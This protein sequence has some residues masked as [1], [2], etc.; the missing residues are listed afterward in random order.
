MS[1]RGRGGKFNKVKRGG[2]KKFSRDLQPL[3]ADGEVVGMWGE[4]PDKV[5]EESSE[6]EA[7][8]E[9]ES[10][11]GEGKPADEELTREQRRE[12]AKK[13][14]AAAIAKK[15]QKAPEAGDMPTDSEEDEDDDMPANPNHT[16][17]ARTQA[18]KAPVDPDAEPAAT[19]A[20]KGKGKQPDLSQL[21]RREREALQA[22]A[23]KDR[24]E[25]LHAEGKTEQARADLERLRLVRER[26]DAEAARKKAEAEER[27]ELE[28]EKKELM[29][30]ENR[31]R[32]QAQGKANRLAKGGKKNS[33]S[34][35]EREKLTT[36]SSLAPLDKHRHGTFGHYLLRRLNMAEAVSAQ[37]QANYETFRDCLSEPILKALAVPIEQA[38]PKKN[39]KRYAKKGL[40]SSKKR[41]VQQET[42]LA[43]FQPSSEA[44]QADAE[45]LGEFIEY[46]STLLFPSL[47]QDVRTLTHAIYKETPRLQES[48]TP[49]LSASTTTRLLNTIPPPAIDSLQS[50]ALLPPISDSI[51]QHNLFTPI[52]TAYI[53]ACIAPPPIWSTTRATAC[54][55]CCRDWVPLTYHHLL[56]KQVHARVLKRGWHT[57]DKLNSVAWLCRACHN[58]VH[59]LAGNEDLAKSYYTIEL[60]KT[61]GVEGDTDKRL[62]VE[63][64]VGWVGGVRWKSR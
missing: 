26:R 51:D 41:V 17:K 3:N 28:K 25:K 37:E 57:E 40:K 4:Q 64:W 21:S 27:A 18:A 45:D 53:T 56:P 36:S 30:R 22:Q 6:E 48:Y 12:L 32:E 33:A 23:S 20:A 49:P 46:L 7:S 58:F 2:G 34:P 11:D 9:E 60:I 38:K 31:R 5:G 15:S 62:E 63:G 50:Y 24:Y 55:L 13:R 44:Q 10:S 39:K 47:P 61:G 19:A 29:D 14:K 35:H 8:S 52:L 54:E 42:A 1:G 16:A 43:P 59:R